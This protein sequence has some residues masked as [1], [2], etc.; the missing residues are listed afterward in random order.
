MGAL[1]VQRTLAD[2][3][4]LEKSGELRTARALYRTLLN[5]FPKNARA[6]SALATLESSHPSLA[7]PPKDLQQKILNL[8]RASK[9]PDLSPVLATAVAEYPSSAF[10]WNMRGITAKSTGRHHNC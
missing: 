8:F 6:K 9:F 5:Q 7:H 10:L 2:A 3:K 4:R 1:N